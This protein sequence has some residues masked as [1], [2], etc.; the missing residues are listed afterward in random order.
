[1]STRAAYIFSDPDQSFTVYK[2]Y[3]GHPEG[4]VEAIIK[5]RLCAWDLP[6]FEADEFAAAFVSAN[7]DNAGQVRLTQND[8][9][10][11]EAF[12]D[13]EY[14]YHV[15]QDEYGAPV[16]VYA[17][18]GWT[19]EDHTTGDLVLDGVLLSTLCEEDINQVEED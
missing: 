4:A 7:K 2:H 12:G 3:D 19:G 18:T 1:M 9:R 17:W 11:A 8:R 16:R 5:A 10:P 6:R 14:I 15:R 13:L